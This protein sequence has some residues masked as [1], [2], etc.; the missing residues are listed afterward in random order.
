M[1]KSRQNAAGDDGDFPANFLGVFPNKMIDQKRDVCLPFTKRRNADGKNIQT[2]EQV[3]TEG[4][5][6]DSFFQV[7][8]G[9]RNDTHIGAQRLGSTQTYRIGPRETKTETYTWTVPDDIPEG[10]VRV[11]AEISYRRLVASVGEFLGVPEDEMR[12]EQVN[13]TETWFEVYY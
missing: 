9:C 1:L 4:L 12:T 5:F 3:F 8:V 6:G 2:I 13:R 11:V 7:A 10:K